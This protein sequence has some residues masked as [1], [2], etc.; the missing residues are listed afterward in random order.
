[1]MESFGRNIRHGINMTLGTDNFPKDMVAEMRWASMLSK[2]A[3]FDRTSASS[4]EVFN[5]AT[6]NGAK[7]LRRGDLG[8]LEPGAKADILVIDLQTKRVAPVYD[9]IKSLVNAATSENVEKVCC[10][11][12]LLVDG[13]KVVGVDEETLVSRV[14]EI[15]LK[16][17]ERIPEW[18]YLGREAE[19]YAPPS[20]KR[21]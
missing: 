17:W 11:G 15:A 6:L 7:S 3:D 9:P 18:D 4:A 20:F 13:G 19:E 2:V 21:L 16:E 1:M 12:I 10:D 14:Q 8:R 5:A